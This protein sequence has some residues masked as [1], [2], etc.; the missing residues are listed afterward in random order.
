MFNS[1]PPEI[2]NKIE[3]T[4]QVKVDLN[5]EEIRLLLRSLCAE[6]ET[7]FYGSTE[8]QYTEYHSKIDSLFLRL[9]EY[10]NTLV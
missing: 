10:K 1:N 4:P 9:V 2:V 8:E 6:R 5:L 7:L 3:T